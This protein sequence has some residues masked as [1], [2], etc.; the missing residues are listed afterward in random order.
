MVEKRANSKGQKVVPG[1]SH[2]RV[3]RKDSG[4]GLRHFVPWE[5]KTVSPLNQ[6]AAVVDR[7]R[8]ENATT[9]SL[10]SECYASN[11]DQAGAAQRCLPSSSVQR[12][13]FAGN[14]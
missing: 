13:H 6:H 14:A 9:V 1:L 5:S 4:H 3:M 12:F 8:S 11:L 7:C 2:K 10:T